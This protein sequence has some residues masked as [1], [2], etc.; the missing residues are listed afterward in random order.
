LPVFNGFSTFCK[1][2]TLWKICDKTTIKIFIAPKTCRYTTLRKT[3]YAPKLLQNCSKIAP[4]EAQQW[5]TKRAR[6]KGNVAMVDGS[7]QDQLHIHYLVLQAAQT[8]VMWTNFSW[9]S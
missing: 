2:Q 1:P 6:T 8:G 4:I 5:Q 3:Y 7:Q 9:R